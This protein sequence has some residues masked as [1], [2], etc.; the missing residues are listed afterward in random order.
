MEVTSNKISKK[1]LFKLLFIGLTTSMSIF[2][3]LCGVAALFGAQTIEWNGVHRT[4]V[5]GLVYSFFMGP[6]IGLIFSCFM[7]VFLVTGLWVYSFF[8]PIT[9]SFKQVSDEQT[10]AI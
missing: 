7:W 10:N 6:L 9:M 2:C 5:E 4:G 8:K 3:I 1:S